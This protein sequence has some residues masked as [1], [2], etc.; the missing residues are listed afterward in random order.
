MIENLFRPTHL[1]LVLTVCL[2][3]WG[4]K[5]LPLLG[6]GVGQAIRGF[7][8]GLNESGNDEQAPK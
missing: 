4:P 1:L 3:V 2:F 6:K 5:N 8:D 7:K